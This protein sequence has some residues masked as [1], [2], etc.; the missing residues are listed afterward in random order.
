[1]RP[2]PQVAFALA[3]L[4]CAA[5]WN[6]PGHRTITES[7][8]DLLPP[9][10][11]QWLQTPRTREQIAFQANEPDRW[12]GTK[13]TVLAHENNP[14]HFLDI[15]LL[16][17][18]G[19]ALNT[20]PPLRYEFVGALARAEKPP[21]PEPKRGVNQFAKD[22]V[23]YLPY[24][25]VEHHAKLVA[26]FTTVRILEQLNEPARQAQLD[27]ARANVIRE[28][29]QLSHF[30]GDAGQPLHTT[31]HHHGWIGANPDGFTTERS[32]HQYIDGD[33]VA[34]HGLNVKEI[35]KVNVPI[36]PITAATVWAETIA[37]IDRSFAKVRPL[38]ELQKSGE[39][40]RAAGH[41]FIAQRMADSASV[42]AGLY[43]EAWQ[44]SAPTEQQ[45]KDFVRFDYMGAEQSAPAVDL[46]PTLTQWGLPPRG[47]GPRGTCSV[48]TT[49]HAI[50][51]ALAKH[52]GKGT[53]L[54]PE[55]LN[56]AAS[57][58]AGA[59]SD[60]AFFHNALA[61]FQRY[62]V[63]SEAELPY[64]A[65]YDSAL[66]PSDSVR[67][68][69]ESMRTNTAESLQIRW[70]VP[71]Q[72]ARFGVNDQQMEEILH[73]LARGYP[74]AAGSGHSRLL[75]GF[76][77]DADSPGG[78]VFLTQDSGLGRYDEVTFDFVRHQV[79]DVFWI[80]AVT[81]R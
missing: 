57:Q 66:K 27:A 74:V 16:E 62:G 25:I 78:G 1:M 49:C 5:A 34:L 35:A 68:A 65:T 81:V 32:F 23:G 6:A 31:I 17:G 80:E 30:V 18:S 10:A 14:D 24:S 21:S 9:E 73:V 8:L 70:I 77:R 29:G 71:W 19:L 42:L 41:D 7:A 28:M 47:Q 40:Q 79:A 60:G 46:R 53:R 11:P 4:A 48:F 50:E 58:V 63:C 75:V 22:E 15:E 59:P 54:S 13:L 39:L 37:L 33:V 55:F 52:T 36:R 45:V 67:A 76:R 26:S 72:P 69:A 64:Q 20:L 61:G 43:W 44:S 56:W 38:Y 3:M 2:L 12:R 51:F